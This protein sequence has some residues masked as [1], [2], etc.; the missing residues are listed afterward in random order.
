MAKKK[1]TLFKIFDI[2]RDVSTSRLLLAFKYKGYLVETGWLES[3]KRK[4]PV[5]SKGEAIPWTTYS[6]IRFIDKYLNKSMSMFEF[7]TGNSTKY[8]AP[9]VK[10]LTSVENDR[11]WYLNINNEVRNNVTLIFEEEE[12]D[13]VESIIKTSKTYIKI[14]F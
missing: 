7:G 1:N 14:T 4:S 6:F 12:I 3:Y 9:R 13:Y 11:N 2:I 8:Y 5:N 10:S